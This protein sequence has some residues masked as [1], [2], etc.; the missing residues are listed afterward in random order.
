M[1]SDK[2]GA[3]T[4][5]LQ[6]SIKDCDEVANRAFKPLLERQVAQ[7]FQRRIFLKFLLFPT[8]KNSP[9]IL[10]SLLQA[11]VERIRS[12][13][14]LLQ[15]FRTLFNLPSEL[16]AFVKAGE[17][18]KAVTEYNKAKSLRLPVNVGPTILSSSS[19]FSILIPF[20][21]PSPV[22]NSEKGV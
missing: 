19:P 18:D 20:H 10:F 7:P 1:E 17:Y 14:G 3:G 4:K 12:V 9:R 8:Y 5:K 2:D 21:L 15:R 6:I 13:Q 16:R 22:W 11:Q